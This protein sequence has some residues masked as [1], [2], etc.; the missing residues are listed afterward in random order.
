M[1]TAVALAALSGLSSGSAT[2]LASK[3]H[4]A[5]LVIGRSLPAFDAAQ[6]ARDAALAWPVLRAGAA[7]ERS[8]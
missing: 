8:E 4:T 2:S 1:M 6:T 3:R 7:D 5:T